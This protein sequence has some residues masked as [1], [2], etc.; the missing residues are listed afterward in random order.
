MEQQ[1]I[2]RCLK[3]FL[4]KIPQRI[5]GAIL[6]GSFGRG[7]GSLLSDIDIELLVIEDHLDIDEFTNEIVE[8][9]KHSEE[10]LI[11]KHTIWLAEQRKLALYHGSQLLLTELYLYS[12]QILVFQ[13]KYS[14]SFDF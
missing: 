4:E 11:I 12:K 13:L 6:I 1:K 14:F 10:A 5:Q 9:F 7:E 8:L 3:A 2:I